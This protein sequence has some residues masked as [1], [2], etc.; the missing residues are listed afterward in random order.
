MFPSS[1]RRLGCF[2]LFFFAFAWSSFP[3]VA[4]EQAATFQRLD[5][6]ELVQH[7]FN[8][9]DSFHVR[10][11]SKEY[12]FRLYFVDTPEAETDYAQRSKDQAAYFGIDRS[13]AIQLG[14]EAT[15]FTK[16]QLTGTFTVY[17]RWCNALGRS[18]LPRHY[19]FVVTGNSDLA[20]LLV[21]NGLARIFGTK[22]ALPDGRDSRDYLAQIASFEQ[23]AKAAGLGGWNPK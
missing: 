23:E 22:T 1:A 10:Y 8:D 2:G 13:R 18:K 17:T 14:K 21:K 3:A 15:A 7:A 4:A 5:G 6:C 16:K 9:G 20:A 12:I 19:A 11:Q